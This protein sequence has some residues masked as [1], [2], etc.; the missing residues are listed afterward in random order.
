MATTDWSSLLK[1]TYGD[2]VDPIPS[3]GTIAADID[4][5]EAEKRPGDTF[6]F[7]VRLQHEAGFTYNTDHEAFDLESAVDSVEGT[8][9][10]EGSEIAWV[11]QL[12]TGL[13]HK[14]NKSKG[15]SGRAYDQAIGRKILY[16]MEAAENRREIALLYGGGSGVLANLGVIDTVVTNTGTSLV[17]TITQATYAPG[18][19]AQLIGAKF[20]IYTTGG[21]QRTANAA[22]QLTG[23]NKTNHRLTFLKSSSDT[24]FNAAEVFF[25]RGA[26]AKTCVGLQAIL[27]NT[28]SLFGISAATYPQWRAESYAVGGPLTFDKVVE[29]LAGCQENGLED[30]TNL[31]LGGRA[32]T[33]LMTDEAALRRH[34]VNGEVSKKVS[35]GYRELSFNSLCGPITIK[36]HRFMKQGLAMAVPVQRAKRVGS[37]DLTFSAPGS[38]NEWFFRELESKM[39][40]QVRCYSDQAV[41]LET[42]NHATLYTGIVSTSDV[43]PA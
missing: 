32:W 8:A 23:I 26:R 38:K 34:V 41:V 40:C 28:G 27:E 20:D 18:M 31:Y 6:E 9:R 29:G 21:T 5:I 22:V 13:M 15:V 16:G 37:T 7:P 11:G 30:G 14:M 12:S 17:V 36:T 19:W 39:G 10:L 42:P 1:R 3:E 43:V 33:D 35:T 25:F 24:T 4:F 2:P